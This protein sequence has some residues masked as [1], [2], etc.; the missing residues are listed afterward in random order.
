[1]LRINLVLMVSCFCL[2]ISCQ[3]ENV[4]GGIFS[5]K[6]VAATS[7]LGEKLYALPVSEDI[8]SQLVEKEALYTSDA[9]N[10]DHLIWYGR[11][12]AYA[13]RYQEAIDLYTKGIALAPDD[14]RLYRHR[15]HRYITIRKFDEAEA[16]LEL[17]STIMMENPDEVEPDGI[18]N[19]KGI[20][21]TSLYSNVWYHLGLVRYLK[22][23][24]NPA[25]LAFQSCILS[26]TRADNLV[27]A[28]NWAYMLFKRRGNT[29]KAAGSL[30]YIKDEMHIIENQAY[31]KICLF[32]QGIISA[33]ELLAMDV[34]SADMDA[35]RYAIANAQ[36][37][38]LKFDKAE[39]LF[40]EII[41]DG[42]WNSFGYI[43][44]EVELAK[45]KK[46][47]EE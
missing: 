5:K 23:E 40:Q 28:T 1:M 26:S 44:A 29:I 43:A 8:L 22:G 16:D 15:G 46:A 41:A 36:F 12:L 2:L 3:N 47:K 18:P 20:P 45:M 31:H 24:H 11:F 10:I 38:D 13:G 17:A 6:E 33:E 4:L 7:L 39:Q 9:S 14:A 19:A 37:N 32:H 21:L 35:I 25:L 34:S 27:A 30:I 42:D